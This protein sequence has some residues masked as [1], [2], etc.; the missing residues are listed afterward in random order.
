MKTEAMALKE[1]KDRYMEEFERSKGKGNDVMI[2]SKIKEV[3][4]QYW[5]ICNFTRGEQIAGSIIR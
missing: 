1:G 4:K 5:V 3:I 2:I